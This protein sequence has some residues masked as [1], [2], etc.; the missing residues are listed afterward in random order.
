MF[1][2]DPSAVTADRQ[3][4]DDVRAVCVNFRDAVNKPAV[5]GIA[6]DPG[7]VVGQLNRDC[8]GH[9]GTLGRGTQGFLDTAPGIGKRFER[10]L[11]STTPAR[12]EQQTNVCRRPS[13]RLADAIAT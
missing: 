6:S 1:Q 2:R 3:L 13:V 5:N 4:F 10:R 8:H 11:S 7:V 12:L 9:G